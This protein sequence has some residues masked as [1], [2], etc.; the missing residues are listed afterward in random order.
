MHKAEYKIDTS[1]LPGYRLYYDEM[2][3]TTAPYMWIGPDYYKFFSK[4]NVDTYDECDEN[5]EI[6]SG[7]RR[8]RLWNNVDEYNNS[9]YRKRQWCFRKAI[10]MDEVIKGLNN[11]PFIPKDEKSLPD[12]T[13]E[14]SK[15]EF[16]HGGELLAKF[17][18]DKKGRACNKSCA[19]FCIYREMKGN[20]IVW[21][22]KKKLQ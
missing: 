3:F 20:T 12:P 13:M 4:E 7:F 19:D 1:Y 10:N 9:I 8:I 6:A 11:K 5:V 14:I 15:G 18:V 17:Y 2:I 21:Q 22:E 16:E